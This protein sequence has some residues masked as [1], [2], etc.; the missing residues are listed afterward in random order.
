MTSKNNTYDPAQKE[1]LFTFYDLTTG[2]VGPMQFFGLED[3]LVAN[4]PRGHGAIEGAYLYGSLRVCKDGTVEKYKPEPPPDTQWTSHC[5]D[6]QNEYWRA[7]P[8]LAAKRLHAAERIGAQ[9]KAAEADQARPLR[10]VLLA[11]NAGRVPPPA[12]S[13]RLARADKRMAEMRAA[14]KAT[15][16]AAADE[17]PLLVAEALAPAAETIS[18]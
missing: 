8:S 2:H 17:L 13:D 1:K 15:A 5:W 6:E 9:I 16:E 10:E 18:P 11:L 4:T 7:E 12:A 3:H 14:L